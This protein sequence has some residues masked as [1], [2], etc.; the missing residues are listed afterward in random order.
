MYILNC[1]HAPKP[2][3]DN[4]EFLNLI[5]Q[6]TENTNNVIRGKAVLMILLLIKINNKTLVHLSEGKF[7]NFIEKL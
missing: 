4:K 2:Y 5:V 6:L 7:F 3:E 1:G